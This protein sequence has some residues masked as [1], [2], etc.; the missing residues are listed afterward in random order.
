[1]TIEITQ[2]IEKHAQNT[3]NSQNSSRDIT[4]A[5]CKMFDVRVYTTVTVKKSIVIISLMKL[6]PVFTTLIIW[7]VYNL[8]KTSSW[9]QFL[10]NEIYNLALY[11]SA[12]IW[13][14]YCRCDIKHQMMNQSK[15]LIRRPSCIWTSIHVFCLYLI[16]YL[17]PYND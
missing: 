6:K 9:Y 1:M 2:Q 3:K 8:H 11:I 13:L 15:L 5:Y 10:D 17:Y 16:L 7:Y 4:L 14:K 12:L